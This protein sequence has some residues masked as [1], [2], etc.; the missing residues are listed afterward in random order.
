MLEASLRLDGIDQVLRR[1]E[2]L[3]PIAREKALRG[4]MFKAMRPVLQAV[5]ASTPRRSGALRLAMKRVY[6]RP[7]ARQL[8]DNLAARVAVAPKTRDRRALA[9]ANFSYGRTKRLRGVYWGHFVEFGTKR[10]IRPGRFMQRA[11]QANAQQVIDI[12][13]DDIEKQ[14]RRQ[15][16]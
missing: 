7:T 2:G 16:K 13:A 1:L 15:L 11:I 12:F 4:A 5:V 14:V 9:L 3:S 6:L 10:G 8:V